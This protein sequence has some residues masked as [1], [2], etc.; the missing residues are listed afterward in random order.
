MYGIRI[1]G[2]HYPWTQ[3]TLA[4]TWTR[5]PHNHIARGF[6]SPSEDDTGLGGCVDVLFP[7]A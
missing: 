2:D 3:L 1:I 6:G 5:L 7:V 4:D